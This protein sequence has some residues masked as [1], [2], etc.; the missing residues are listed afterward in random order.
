[1][2]LAGSSSLFP[3]TTPQ[4]WGV[5]APVAVTQGPGTCCGAKCKE[6]RTAPALCPTP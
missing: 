3:A 1:M 2:L 5:Q 4:G 6:A